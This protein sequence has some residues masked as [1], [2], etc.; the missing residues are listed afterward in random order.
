MPT[1]TRIGVEVGMKV[2]TGKVVSFH[3][4][5]SEAGVEIDSSH[6]RGEP[7]AVLIGHGG[8]IVGLEEALMGRTAGEH[9]AVSVEPERAYGERRDGM[10]QRVPKKYF[11]DPAQLRP[12][13]STVLRNREGSLRSVQVVK[14]GSSVVDVDLN[15]PLAGR[16]LDFDIELVDVREA[17]AEELSHGHAHGP[18][19]HAH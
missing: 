5:V 1:P 15:H 16:T 4:R 7:L 19:G 18:D 17:T 14:V 9:F 8:I 3:Y 6:A 10:V 12:G 11:R 2:E 13:M